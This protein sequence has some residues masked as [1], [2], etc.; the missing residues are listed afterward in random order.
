[1]SISAVSVFYSTFTSYLYLLKKYSLLFFLF[2]LWLCLPT[3]AVWAQEQNE[4][5]N[6]TAPKEY[7]IGGI[8]VKGVEHLDESVLVSLSG[9][10]VGDKIAV[11][12]E[13]ISNAVKALWK[14]GLFADVQIYASKIVGDVIFLEYRLQ[15]LP[16]L[17]R[18]RFNGVKKGEADEL[19]DKV[20]LIAGKIVNQ[21]LKSTAEIAIKRY[22]VD[23]G[24]L[25]VRVETISE[26]D[27]LRSN[28]VVL[29]FDIKRGSRVRIGEVVLNGNEN[30]YDRNLKKKLK[31][32]KERTSINPKAP[33]MIVKDALHTN[34]P[35][36]LSNLS[37]SGTLNYL[38]DKIRLHP[39]SSSKFIRKDYEK[40]KLALIDFYNT[41]GYRDAYIVSD[42]VYQ[43]DERNLT[44]QLNINEGKKYYF[45]NIEWSGN[46]K[47]TDEQL[48]NLLGIEKG[49]VYDQERL[50]KR[51]TIDPNGGD[52]ISSLYMD[53]GYLF[54]NVNP[55]EKNIEND[56][57][58]LEMRIYEGAQATINRIIV[59]G[60]D[61]TSEH[62]I[63]RE[64]FTRPGSQFSRSDII[65]SQRQLAQL[66]YFNPETIGIVPKPNPANGTVD[67]EYSVEERPSDQ[68]ELS[69]GWGGTGVIGS[70]GVTFNN[71]SLK[72]LLHSGFMPLPAGDGQRLSLRVQTNGKRYQS[73]N[74]SFTEPWLG[75]RKPNELTFSVFR[76]RQATGFTTGYDF[77]PTSTF[78]NT[79]FAVTTGRRLSWPDNNFV[80]IHTASYSN[81]NLDNFDTGFLV[82]DGLFHNISLETILRR[83]SLDQ[84]LFPR[85]GSNMSLSMELTPPYSLFSE[86]DY[87][88][89]SDAAKYKFP[90]YFK[91]RF[92]SEWYTS[93]I[94]NLVLR[95]SAKMGFMGYYNSDIGY[96]PF[97]RFQVGGDGLSN[98]FSNIITGKDIIALRGYEVITSNLVERENGGTAEVGDPFF[99]KFTLELRYPFSLNPSSTIYGLAFFEAGNSWSNFKEYNPLQLRR[100]VGV[101]LRV[102]LPM[103]GLMGVDYGVGFD[104]ETQTLSGTSLG[105]Y[106]SS[107]GKFSFILGFEPE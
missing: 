11:P 69:A 36:L 42:S 59:K 57:I 39:L 103:F 89:L 75:G 10:R 18:Y 15:E 61:K 79:G 22:F 5:L 64:L 72:K 51:L 74:F 26:K 12:G 77:T 3:A 27:T 37:L 56:S 63:R 8:V 99:H 33:F 90:E 35:H 28:N 32:T 30:F 71:F 43:R 70:V 48:S 40:D 62:V 13:P 49:D 66:G 92:T 46:T 107:Y 94:G 47:Y 104:K 84:T 9:L 101:G 41:K 14:Q 44:V 60:N 52:D 55:V 86:K 34:I 96:A 67:I 88:T 65:R 1:M 29:E 82:S 17:S 102:F 31:D 87:S 73:V 91:W 68:L 81:Y 97:E 85:G 78:T 105:G 45:R 25:N 20:N 21:N 83:N 16:R 93:I 98:S 38:D 23:K 2:L 106:L 76:T 95:S 54:F 6:Y 58:D 53:D 4:Q 50:Q 24:F 100:S 19:G 80:L 7:E